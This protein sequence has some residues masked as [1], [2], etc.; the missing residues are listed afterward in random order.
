MKKSGRFQFKNVVVWWNADGMRPRLKNGGIIWIVRINNVS[1]REHKEKTQKQGI[2]AQKYN[3][4]MCNIN[5]DIK[6][7]WLLTREGISFT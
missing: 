4:K 7:I 2:N 1:T 5:K 6:S 3:S